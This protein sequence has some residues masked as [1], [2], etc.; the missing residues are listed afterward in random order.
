MITLTIWKIASMKMTG[1]FTL[2]N[3]L[4]D[5]SR[6][7]IIS[8]DTLTEL[9]FPIIPHFREDR[10][11]IDVTDD[12]VSFHYRDR[13]DNDQMKTTSLNPLEFI[14]RFFLHVLPKGFMRIR[15]FG[16]L[17]NR[18][19]MDYL[20]KCRIFLGLPPN[21][22]KPEKKSNQ[23]L[24]LQLTGID[25]SLCPRCKKGRMQFMGEIPKPIDLSFRDFLIKP[26]ILDSS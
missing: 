6:C 7:S 11:I 3:L 8:A 23:E 2:K 25:I 16:F 12:K 4:Q 10:R 19:K 5:Q 18:W 13:S 24:M 9:L 22:I 14:R 20:G 15:H 26:L 1:L 17:A 21:P